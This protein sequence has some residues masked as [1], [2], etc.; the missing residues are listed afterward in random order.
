MGA[1]AGVAQTL[2]K[3]QTNF[4]ATTMGRSNANKVNDPFSLFPDNKPK[5]VEAPPLPPAINAPTVSSAQLTAD[6]R[7]EN[8]AK[9]RGQASTILSSTRGTSTG[10]T[11][12]AALLGN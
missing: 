6:D 10:T 2:M 12:G 5:P 1:V 7:A 4:L 8:L 3:P 9:R 11:S